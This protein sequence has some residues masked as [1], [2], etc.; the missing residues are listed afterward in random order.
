M[1]PHG[2]GPPVVATY[3]QVPSF[4]A[5]RYA[6]KMLVFQKMQIGGP[7]FYV[8]ARGIEIF[9]SDYPVISVQITVRLTP[10]MAGDNLHETHGTRM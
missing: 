5:V 7:Q 4:Q 10:R 6:R 1:F 2:G 8:D 3:A 9:G